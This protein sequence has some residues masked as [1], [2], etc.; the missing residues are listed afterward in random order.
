MEEPSQFDDVQRDDLFTDDD[1]DPEVISLEKIKSG[2]NS[3]IEG[4]DASG[5][6]KRIQ[7][8]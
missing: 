1:N 6:G 4:D 7:I 5:K 3:L 8:S 2:Y